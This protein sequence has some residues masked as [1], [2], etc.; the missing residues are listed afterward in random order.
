[1]SQEGVGGFP[2]PLIMARESKEYGCA[3]YEENKML[4]PRT[5]FGKPAPRLA[6]GVCLRS[7]PGLSIVLVYRRD[8]AISEQFR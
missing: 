1:M 8:N 7:T 4:F 2:F 3:F 5:P 6:S